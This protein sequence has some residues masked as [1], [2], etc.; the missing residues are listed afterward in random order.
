MTGFTPVS[1]GFFNE[2]GFGIML[3]EELGLAVHQLGEMG[4]ER[5][6]DLRVQVL[7]RAPQKAAVSRILHQRVLKGID[8]VR[9][10]A[11]LENQLGGD[12]ASESIMQLVIGETG[13]GA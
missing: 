4:F 13:D 10:L 1:S 7:P 6:G 11:T 2:P 5:F 12:K 9:R 3:R 8:R